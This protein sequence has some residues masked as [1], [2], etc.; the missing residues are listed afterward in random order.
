MRFALF[1]D[2]APVRSFDLIEAYDWP[3]VAFIS[4]LGPLWL[5]LELFEEVRF[6]ALFDFVRDRLLDFLIFVF[7]RFGL[8]TL[9]F[10]LKIPL[11]F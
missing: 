3:N 6:G 5:D 2:L 8:L 4:F 11:Y 1:S 9:Y 7:S 10:Y